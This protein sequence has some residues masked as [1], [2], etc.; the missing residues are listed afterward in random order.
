MTYREDFTLPAEMLEQVASQGFEVLR[1]DNVTG[2]AG[3]FFP[4]SRL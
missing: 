1:D 2:G 3:D 4:L